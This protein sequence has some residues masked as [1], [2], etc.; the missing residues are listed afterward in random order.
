[1]AAALENDRRVRETSKL[2]EAAEAD[3][4][5]LLTRLGRGEGGDVIVGADAGLRSVMERVELVSRSDVP[6]LILGETGSGKEVVA[7][8]IHASSRRASG[9]FLRANCGA[10]PPELI[11]SELFGHERGSFTGA[12]GLR[13]GWFERAD[14]GTL[15]LDEIGELAPH[16]QV[17]LLRV[18][19]E[20]EII[21]I[22]ATLPVPVK[23]R[24]IAGTNRDLR[25]AV[26]EGRFREDLY[27]RLNV[28]RF[29]VPP[30]RERM[31]DVPL[32]AQHMIE[33]L[34]LRLGREYKGVTSACLE[35]LMS[36]AW[37]GN[38]RELG[39]SIEHAMIVGDGE[40]IRPSDLPAEVGASPAFAQPEAQTLDQALRRFEKAYLENELRRLAGNRRDL[41]TKLG[42]DPSTLYRKIQAFGIK[43]AD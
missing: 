30:L 22:G 11:D 21:P 33:R 13:K 4:R 9:P 43:T 38:V 12:I 25:T 10:I 17:K 32:L 27:Y 6:V 18:I 36:H 31:D 8:A 7:R 28:V 1:F 29:E 5:S 26:N 2:R 14:G 41:A 37:K 35:V 3:R 16:L 42:I 23:V 40:W 15:L 24:V 20:K 34:N 39:H 19:E